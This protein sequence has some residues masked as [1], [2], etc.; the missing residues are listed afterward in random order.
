MALKEKRAT[1]M[2]AKEIR[3]AKQLQIENEIQEHQQ[4]Q[5]TQ[6]AYLYSSK[7]ENTSL[8][9]NSMSPD[10]PS[11]KFI[12]LGYIEKDNSS[13]YNGSRRSSV[14]SSCNGSLVSEN[15]TDLKQEKGTNFDDHKSIA[16]KKEETSGS[17]F[18]KDGLMLGASSS[19]PPS[20]LFN[21]ED[22]DN[23]PQDWSANKQKSIKSENGEWSTLD[24]LLNR[25]DGEGEDSKN[26]LDLIENNEENAPREF[27]SPGDE[28][29]VSDCMS[30][31]QNPFPNV[32]ELVS[33][34][35]PLT[36][37][38]NISHTMGSTKTCIYPINLMESASPISTQ[39]C[40]SIAS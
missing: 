5:Q 28:D 32:E 26:T 17:W 2:E 10:E 6:H 9:L 38:V 18:N 15:I 23:L 33:G 21:E 24:M 4:R 11:S 7:N 34:L 39:T 1:L 36:T 30:Q 12:R 37:A 14:D 35:A 19:H 13:N 25:R 29:L 22:P 27:S 8:P 20:S 16:L 40:S 31:S 3:K